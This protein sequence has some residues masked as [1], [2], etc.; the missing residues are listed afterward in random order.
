MFTLRTHA[1]PCF[2]IGRYIQTKKRWV[3]FI[4]PH[5]RD[6]LLLFFSLLTCVGEAADNESATKAK[7]SRRMSR[8]LFCLFAPYGNCL[9][10][11][12][13]EDGR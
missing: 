5:R 8:T 4:Y 2:T 10:W 6:D 7:M 1:L 3:A 11:S 13:I 12:S 9:A